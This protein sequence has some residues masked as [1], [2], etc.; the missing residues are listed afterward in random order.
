MQK[1]L[2]KSLKWIF[3]IFLC[4]LVLLVS[5]ALVIQIPSVQNK[6]VQKVTATLSNKTHSVIKLEKIS[7]VF[8]GRLSLD[9]I[10]AEDNRKDTL[11]FAGNISAGFNITDLLQKELNLSYISVTNLKTHIHNSSTDS[12]MNYQFI[13]DAFVD[14]TKKDISTSENNSEENSFQ[15]TLG[16][17]KLNDIDLAYSDFKS[18]TYAEAR[19]K[20]LSL[21]LDE[22]DLKKSIFKIDD[23]IID[24][25]STNIDLPASSNDTSAGNASLPFITADKISIKNSAV[26]YKSGGKTILKAAIENF[27]QDNLYADLSKQTIKLKYLEIEQSSVALFSDTLTTETTASP[28]QSSGNNWNISI[29]KIETKNNNFSMLTSGFPATPVFNP[30]SFTYS[31]ITFNADKVNYY[32]GSGG[33]N[34]TKASL[35]TGSNFNLEKLSGEVKLSPTESSIKNVQLETSASNFKGDIVLKYKSLDS[36]SNSIGDL[37]VNA[38]IN[39]SRFSTSDI[40]WFTPDQ[41]G[42]PFLNNKNNYVSFRGKIKGPIKDLEGKNLNISTGNQ[43][44][45]TTNFSAKGLPEITTTV[46]NFP[47]LKIKTSDKDLTNLIGKEN[48]PST[49]QLP[50]DIMLKSN[51]KGTL[52]SFTTNTII[53]T[54]KGNTA[55]TL[56]MTPDSH[57][58]AL[59]SVRELNLG[60]ILKNKQLG[61]TTL[62]TEITGIGLDTN[63]I[64][65]AVKLTVD[66][67]YFNGYNYSDINADVTIVKQEIAG[68]LNIADP[69]LELQLNGMMNMAHQEK[70]C[71]INLDLKG[72]DLNKLKLAENDLRISLKAEADLKGNSANTLNGTAGVTQ[73]IFVKDENKYILDSLLLATINEKGKS[74]LD[75]NSPIVSIQYNGTVAI[76][77]ISGELKHFLNNYFPFFKEETTALNE[78]SDFDFAISIKNHPVVRE[79]FLPSLREFNIDPITGSFN[80]SDKVLKFHML[81]KSLTYDSTS[82]SNLSIDVS[83]DPE[84]ISYA[85][86]ADEAVNPEIKIINFSANGNI[87][88][89]NAFLNVS[90]FNSD[91]KQLIGLN[92]KT[93]ADENLYKIS[94]DSSA[95]IIASKAWSVSPGNFVAVS[96]DGFYIHG[97]ELKSNEQL[98]AINSKTPSILD[99]IYIN[100]KKFNLDE[101]SEQLKK[102]KKPFGGII[103]GDV[104]V[105]K[106]PAGNGLSADLTINNLT[107]NEVQAGNLELHA[108]PSG[109]NRFKLNATLKGDA[110]NVKVEGFFSPADTVSNLDLHAE[111]LNFSMNSIQSF[112]PEQLSESSGTLQGK[113]HITGTTGKPKVNGNLHF[114]SVTTIPSLTNSKIT[115][116]DETINVD[117]ESISLNN[118]TIKD[119]N[120]SFLRINGNVNRIYT[121]PVFNLQLS[122]K[123]FQVTDLPHV[124]NRDYSGRL[125]IDNESRITGNANLPVV[126]SKLTIRNNSN[127]TFSVPEK[128]MTDDRGQDVVIFI[129]SLKL[130]PILIKEEAQVVERNELK[131]FD[132]SGNIEVDK[133][134]TLCIVVDPSTND[135]LV[136]RGNAAINFTI[137]PGGKISLTGTYILN[138]GSYIASLESLVKRK[139]AIKSGSTIIWNG[140]PEEAE[141]DITAI[142]TVRTS[143]V[144]LIASQI[145]G[146]SDADKNAFRMRIPFEVLLKMKGSIMTPAIS[147]EIQLPEADKGVLGGQVNAQLA[148]LNENESSL[149]KQVFA[150]LVLGRFVQEDPLQTESGSGVS[151]AARTS[152]SKFLTQQLNQLSASVIHGVDLSFD[153]QSYEDYTTGNAEGR[154]EVGATL[155]KQLFND[156]FTV[157]VGGSVDV[158]G[159][160]SQQNN[161]S[162]ITGDVAV[163][164]ILTEDGR[165]RL[166]GFRHNQYESALEGQITET[167]AGILYS[168][169]FNRW[170]NFLKLTR[171][172]KEQL[173][174]ETA[175]SND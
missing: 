89:G 99:D 9:N 73:L 148:V 52:H 49:I 69:N 174:D 3:Y 91:K 17:I 132:I 74:K 166:K 169:D 61:L 120:N 93:V 47:D 15:I 43:T 81:A 162:D 149:N 5:V 146:L 116:T 57:Y 122:A 151:T 126:T 172:E 154:T 110:N 117:D 28:E 12:I 114:V 124:K 14:T 25:L 153:V 60:Y 68:D 111:I 87:R 164:Y 171:R 66:R 38:D 39:K 37:I 125:I 121:L 134:A 96:K 105:K 83:S 80:S 86:N 157:Q 6:I 70:A 109:L 173:K 118:F 7:L 64:N 175:P 30:H 48:L 18:N 137:D 135:S 165:Y 131:G 133:G 22:T 107:V 104:V 128:K 88:D 101:I 41:K 82:F 156:R 159:E 85:L 78:A 67:V 167:G 160:R 29:A 95:V 150:L 63:T 71:Q 11:L 54:D 145:S 33:I 161:A 35:N 62:Q 44:V 92:T 53:N 100:I 1:V 2:I 147:F 123:N 4:V 127:F 24:G 142:Y 79:V 59:L 144:D 108:A 42:K 84:N 141:A 8:P 103:N 72:A 129:D 152:V 13:I 143:P 51:F 163:E 19:L 102:E 23:L 75:I 27:K 115:L 55:A 138:D 58:H 40:L 50:H 106:T 158:E 170:K 34:I 136:V 31:N 36:I 45:V 155:Q 168:R 90:A 26:H 112:I 46:F 94:I 119:E 21:S 20:S 139:F 77:E 98:I 32:N 97:I 10:Y 140:A 130:N 16:K 65:S 76:S 113:F 56:T